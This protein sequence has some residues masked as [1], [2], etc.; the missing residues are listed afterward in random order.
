MAIR[1]GSAWTV[2]ASNPAASQF[3]ASPHKYLIETNPVLTDL[4][5]FMS[6]DYLLGK[7]ALDQAIAD[8]GTTWDAGYVYVPGI[9]PLDRRHVAW[10]ETMEANPGIK[11]VAQFGTLD[12]P[13]A[14]SVANQARAALQANPTISVVFAPYDEFAKGVMIAVNLQTS[15]LTPPFGF[16]LFYL[17]GVAPPSVRTMDIYRGIVPFVALQ[18]LTVALCMIWPEIILV[19]PRHF[20]F[21]D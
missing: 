7:M 4:K 11:E 12:N 15:F 18:V 21:L 2:K 8:N 10:V 6:S 17:R 13:I 14:N 1:R 20:G 9:A 5:Q 3:A 16:A 19:L